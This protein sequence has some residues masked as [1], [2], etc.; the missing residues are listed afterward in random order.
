MSKRYV[1]LWAAAV[2]MLQTLPTIAQPLGAYRFSVSTLFRNNVFRD[3]HDSVAQ[4]QNPRRMVALGDTALLL[5]DQDN[6]RIRSI[7]I[8]NRSIRT[9]AGDGRAQRIDSIGIF[10][11]LNGPKDLCLVGDSV[12]YFTEEGSHTVRKL[13]LATGRVS[14]LAGGGSGFAN[15]PGSTARF[16]GPQGLTNRGDS[17]LYVADNN[18]NRIR[19]ISLFPTVQVSTFA[20][21]GSGTYINRDSLHKDSINIGNPRSVLVVGNNLVMI[22]NDYNHP[23]IRFMRFGENIFYNLGGQDRPEDL[24]LYRGDTVLITCSGGG[25]SLLVKTLSNPAFSRNLINTQAEGIVAIGNTVYYTIPAGATLNTVNYQTGGPAVR[26][27]GRGRSADG[28]ADE[29][30][31]GAFGPMAQRAGWIYFFDSFSGRIRRFNPESGQM[32]TTTRGNRGNNGNTLKVSFAAANFADIS[33]LAAGSDGRLYAADRQNNQIRALDFAKDSV[34]LIAGNTTG[35]YVNGSLLQ[36]RFSN[37]GS[38]VEHQGKWYV[39]ETGTQPR[40]RAIDALSGTVSTLAGPD[41]AT[42]G[43]YAGYVDSTGANARFGADFGSFFVRNDTLFFADRTNRRLRG[44]VLANQKVFTF[45]GSSAYD[46]F[47]YVFV[48]KTGT[49]VGRYNGFRHD[50]ARLDNINNPTGIVGAAQTGFADG[51][52]VNARFNNP[53]RPVV[54]AATGNLFVP[55]VGNQMIRKVE[56]LLVNQT[57]TISGPASYTVTTLDPVS[58]PSFLQITAG[59]AW[60]S[61][62]SVQVYSVTVA[63]PALFNSLPTILPD[64][65]LSLTASGVNGTTQVRVCVRDN[66]G[67][68]L[69]AVDSA[70]FVF[71]VITNI[72]SVHSLAAKGQI[73]LFPN[74]TQGQPLNWTS[75][76]PVSTVAVFDAVGRK[77]SEQSPAQ[78]FTGRIDL[79]QKGLFYVKILLEDGRQHTSSVEIR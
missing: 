52:G 46:N 24:C 39:A 35:G 42:T 78:K 50:L 64:G 34:F 61:A 1:L 26:F 12:V 8:A 15:G 74:P 17:V 31:I 30:R 57:P 5:A 45:G 65:T 76:S 7:N 48:D 38:I 49:L 2:C 62:Q 69:G 3:G 4:L 6:H 60:E 20:G 77:L 33:I 13:V 58:V 66:G 32:E 54:D 43:N 10:A 47:P 22:E 67:T 72:T 23:V 28:G 37:L 11:S 56:Y 40:I 14:T 68:A 44:V 25:P 71:N 53:G 59:P 18:N 75:A 63:N 16:N 79:Q 21:T 27:F 55:D 70:C 19:R 9:I 41:P 36:A 51:L 73:N 29:A